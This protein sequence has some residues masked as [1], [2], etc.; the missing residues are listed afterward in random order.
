MPESPPII[1]PPRPRFVATEA[2]WRILERRWIELELGAGIGL[3]LL[4]K[5]PLGIEVR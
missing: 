5:R 1:M 3:M 4:L 2:E